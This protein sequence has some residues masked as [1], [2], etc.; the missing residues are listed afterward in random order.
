MKS[1][2]SETLLMLEVLLIDASRK[3]YTVIGRS[4]KTERDLRTIRS[5]FKHEGMSFLTITLPN[6]G[7]QFERALDQ[8]RVSSTSSFQGWK[9]KGCLPAFLWGFTSLVFDHT[10]KL[11]ED[12]DVAAIEAVRQIAYCFKKLLLPCTKQREAASITAYRECEADFDMLCVP[13]NVD[14][15]DLISDLVWGNMF[16][17]ANFDSASLIPK[18][19][20]GTTAERIT[21]NRKYAQVT[22]HE[23]LQPFFPVD[24]YALPCITQD[25]EELIGNVKMVPED[26][27]KPVRVILVPK[28]LKSPRVIAAEPVCMQYTQQAVSSLIIETIENDDITAG[29]V[30]FTCQAINRQLAIASSL[31]GLRATLDLKEASDRVSFQWALRMFNSVPDLRDAIDACRS[32]R[33]KLPGGDLINLQKF[34]SMGSAL[35]FPIEAM[36]FFTIVVLALIERAELPVT[37]SNICSVSRDVYVYGDDLIVPTDAVLSV[38]EMLQ[39]YGCKVNSNK[40]FWNGKFRESCGMDAYNG[41]EVTPTYLRRSIEI[42]DAAKPSDLL[43]WIATSNLFHKRGYWLT[44]KFLS[45]FVEKQVGFQL[46]LV[47]E[48]SPG[49]GWTNFQNAYSIQRWNKKLHRFEVRTLVAT[50]SYREDILDGY[51]ALMKFFLTS[52]H[53]DATDKVDEEHLRRS[54]LHGAV[55]TKRR[56]TTPH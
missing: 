41:E 38:I 18:H 48:D 24:S 9:K 20:P 5:R 50:P 17:R 43:S 55:S 23:R 22:W 36:Y 2:V 52:L 29:H 12:A 33:A 44:A 30:N 49:Q 54:P 13:A 42:D 47:Q 53:R 51:P 40:S 35:C 46:P 21:G 39:L 7:Q 37:I 56:W 14:K 27:E 31:T 15:F 32:R 3:C 26:Q 34:A 4:L 19:G 1:H 8:N 11:K 16:G 10:G 28:T 45:D 6:F 25:V